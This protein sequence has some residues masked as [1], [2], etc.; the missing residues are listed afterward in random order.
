LGATILSLYRLQDDLD[1]M[2]DNKQPS[3]VIKH[4]LPLKA[5]TDVQRKVAPWLADNLAGTFHAFRSLH[6]NRPPQSGLF[7]CPESGTHSG[8]KR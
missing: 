8:I 7:Y 5:G 2:A 4:A 3:I 6:Q 1:R